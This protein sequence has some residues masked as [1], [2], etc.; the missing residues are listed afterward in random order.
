MFLTFLN[1]HC[2]PSMLRRITYFRLFLGAI[3]VVLLASTINQAIFFFESLLN[4]AGSRLIF[5]L[6][7]IIDSLNSSYISLF[8]CR[9][10]PFGFSFAKDILCLLIS[11]WFLAKIC[12]LWYSY[13]R[14][15]ALNNKYFGINPVNK[16]LV[17]LIFF[18]IFSF[19]SHSCSNLLFTNTLSYMRLS[20][21]WFLNDSCDLDLKQRSLHLSSPYLVLL[22]FVLLA[23]TISSVYVIY[24]H[25]FS[26]YPSSMY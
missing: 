15:F 18:T 26:L 14:N 3:F 10:Y 6:S 16:K 20:D 12:N 13:I 21:S 22:C 5:I 25:I 24:C 1:H 19:I 8:V 4:V 2:L 9:F 23:V 17:L 11:S 7:P